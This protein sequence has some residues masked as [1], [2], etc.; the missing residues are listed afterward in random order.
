MDQELCC[1]YSQP[2]TSHAFGG[3]LAAGGR[4]TICI[5]Q[6]QKIQL[7]SRCVFTVLTNFIPIE[8]TEP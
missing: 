3:Q 6:Q 2:I 4:C 8:T 5:M 1:K 7:D